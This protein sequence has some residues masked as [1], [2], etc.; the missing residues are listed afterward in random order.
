MQ[1]FG[2]SGKKGRHSAG[3]THRYNSQANNGAEREVERSASPDLDYY[4][5]ERR[6]RAE[7]RERQARRVEN[8]SSYTGA[9][10]TSSGYNSTQGTSYGAQPQQRFSSDEYVSREERRSSHRWVKKL[11]IALVII[12]AIGIGVYAGVKAWMR[13][14]DIATPGTDDVAES[15]APTDNGV[16]AEEP[17]VIDAANRRDDVYTFLISG[18]DREGFHTDTNIIGMFDI[19]AG[20]LNLVNIPR[21]TLV[22]IDNLHKK[23]NQPYPS[24]I[25]NGGDGVTA[26]LDTVEDLLGYRV[27]FYAI[28]EIQVVE[29]IV[30][31]LGGV[32]YDIPFDMDWDAPDQNPPVSIHIK[33]GYQRLDGENFVNAM[34]FRMSNDGSQTYARGD[35]ERIEFQQKLLMALASQT[36]SLGNITN[37]PKIYDI[38]MSSVDTTLSL[39]NIAYLAA[40]FLKLSSEDISFMTLPS[41]PDGTVYGESYVIPYID[42]WLVMVNEYFNPYTVEITRDNV[43]M[44]ATFDNGATFDT[45]QG[46]VAGGETH[47]YGYYY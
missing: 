11:V 44:I 26:L 24:S 2:G 10:D 29:E 39:G 21:D 30:D 42:D 18:L 20:K 8:S 12:A 7:R 3:N 46:Y 25:N 41:K 22:N 45:T 36:L 17:D 31:A 6:E 15:A 4:E 28:V 14:P 35:I 40:E 1:L 5:E 16:A 47:F 32:Y 43:D 33:A 23:M 38:V 27:D 13:P 34:R 37:L 19:A 9:Q